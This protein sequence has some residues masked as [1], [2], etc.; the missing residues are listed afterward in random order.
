MVQVERTQRVLW[1]EEQD[2]STVQ[3][4]ELNLTG[5]GGK[6]MQGKG[7]LVFHGTCRLCGEW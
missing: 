2:D 1:E 6:G 3:L 5:K 7:S 4:G